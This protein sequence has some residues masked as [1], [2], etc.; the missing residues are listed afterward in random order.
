[1]LKSGEF[2]CS[3]FSFVCSDLSNNNLTGTVP[4][5][6]SQLVNLDRLFLAG[7]QFSGV[8]PQHRATTTDTPVGFVFPFTQ[9]PTAAPVEVEDDDDDDDIVVDDGSSVA[10]IAAAAGGGTVVLL[11]VLIL[12]VGFRAKRSTRREEV[13][14]VLMEA[15]RPKGI[16][17]D[18]EMESELDKTRYEKQE[19]SMRVMPNQMTDFHSHGARTDHFQSYTSSAP[20]VPPRYENVPVASVIPMPRPPLTVS[21]ILGS[22][23]GKDSMFPLPQGNT[24]F[25]SSSFPVPTRGTQVST[26]SRGLSSFYGTKDIVEA[27][28]NNPELQSTVG[29][30]VDGSAPGRKKKRKRKKKKH[31]RGNGDGEGVRHVTT[32]T[33]FISDYGSDVDV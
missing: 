24:P 13:F 21:S 1:M 3:A 19:A 8:M 20:S 29:P 12:V 16:G 7:N 14:E 30:S 23:S 33:T 17:L 9:A 6:I 26:E 32:N 28:T 31:H 22:E 15:N 25:V 5:E 10:A 27:R 2:F 11:L 18:I 4:S